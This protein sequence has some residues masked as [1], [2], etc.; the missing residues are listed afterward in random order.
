M[1]AYRAAQD[2]LPAYA[3]KY[4]PKKF[5]LHQLF[6]CLVLKEFLKRDYRGVVGVLADGAELR[7]A[8]GL[9]HVPHWT[10]LQKASDRLLKSR[11]AQRLLDAT[12]RLARRKKKL[13]KRVKLAAIDSSGFEAQH[14][15]R[16]FAKRRQKLG[17][18]GKRKV[19]VSYKHF[20]KL[21]VVGDCRSHLILA[22]VAEQGPWPDFGC[23]PPAMT[24]AGKRVPIEAVTA[25]MGYDSEAN[26]EY[27]REE[28]KVRTLIPAGHGRPSAQPPTGYW[29]RKMHYHLKQSRYG[30]RWQ[31]ETIISMIKRLLG[32][33]CNARSYWRRCRAL[34]LK[35]LTHNLMI[36]WRY[37][38]ST[39]Q[40]KPSP[41]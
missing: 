13:K 37:R 8:I 35:V 11:P 16:Y 30:Q 19:K 39:E 29:R 6:A 10:T 17:K 36:L 34:L 4:S 21:T 41:A 2:A 26:H 20:P 5:T 23:F 9:K 24:A 40:N 33:D 27:G 28:L 3:H 15:S 7:E 38:F 1:T 22:A 18:D 14:T 31:V 25:D 12:V 32:E